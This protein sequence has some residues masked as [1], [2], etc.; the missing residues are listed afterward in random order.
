MFRVTPAGFFETNLVI[1]TIPESGL[2]QLTSGV[3]Q[4]LQSKGFVLDVEAIATSTLLTKEKVQSIVNALSFIYRQAV[5]QKATAE[6]LKAAL[7]TGTQ[8]SSQ[9]QDALV[10][11]WSARSKDGV[12]QPPAESKDSSLASISRALTLGSLVGV[13]WSVGVG[14]ASSSSSGPQQLGT[15]Y[16]ALTL[17]I[18]APGQPPKA[19]PFELTLREF[20]DFRKA[21]VDMTQNLEQA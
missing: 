14:L 6:Q 1:N 12:L 19:Y 13:D 7:S 3:L 17:R 5:S 20:Q 9:T 16:V 10:T 8:L 18:A 11:A 21:F 4:T 2:N 15:P